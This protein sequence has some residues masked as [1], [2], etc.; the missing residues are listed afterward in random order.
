MKVKN[1][2]NV[3]LTLLLKPSGLNY[4][5]H[6]AQLASRS[7]ID[8]FTCIFFHGK[9]PETLEA[10]TMKVLKN[11]IVV[12]V[13][14]YGIEGIIPINSKSHPSLTFASELMAFVD[15]SG[16]VHFQVFQKIIVNVSVDEDSLSHRRRLKITLVTQ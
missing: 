14:K 3:V 2:P 15:E 12:I 1:I 7:S 4:R 6:N 11:G 16:S 8:L 9:A 10:Y 5:H 13:P